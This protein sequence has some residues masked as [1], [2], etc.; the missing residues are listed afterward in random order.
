MEPD[1][2]LHEER[3]TKIEDNMSIIGTQLTTLLDRDND[4]MIKEIL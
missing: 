2:I 3:L 4:F 1:C